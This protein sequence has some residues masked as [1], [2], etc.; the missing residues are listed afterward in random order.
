[1]LPPLQPS[2]E[3]PGKC[4]KVRGGEGRVQDQEAGGKGS[5]LGSTSGRGEGRKKERARGSGG[6]GGEEEQE[7]WER[8]RVACKAKWGREGA[9]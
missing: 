1:M 8:S 7:P 2:P 6:R 5:A 4:H 3:R 9:K